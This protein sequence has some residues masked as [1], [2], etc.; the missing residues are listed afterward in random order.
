VP[1][2]DGLVA[3]YESVRG[4]SVVDWERH[5]ALACFKV[6]VIAA[7]IDHRRREGASYGEGFATAGD[8]IVPFLELALS[9]T[10]STA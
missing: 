7:G 4:T 6:A 2:V 5:L 9:L 10:R 1:D 8:A 3:R